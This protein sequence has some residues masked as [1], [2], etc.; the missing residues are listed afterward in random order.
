MTYED[1]EVT[2]EKHTIRHYLFENVVKGLTSLQ[3]NDFSSLIDVMKSADWRNV[4]QLSP[5]VKDCID[6]IEGKSI[7]KRLAEQRIRHAILSSEK[8]DFS[9][10]DLKKKYKE[11]ND[12]MRNMKYEGKESQR[13]R[14][15]A[16]L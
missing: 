16:M 11:T 7:S 4:M 9:F 14:N 5:F 6:K 8:L 15:R 1:H 3:T 12:K 2:V 13:E 10:E